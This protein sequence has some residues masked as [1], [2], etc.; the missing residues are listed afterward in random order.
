[1]LLFA[2]SMVHDAYEKASSFRE[3]VDIHKRKKLIPGHDYKHAVT[4]SVLTAVGVFNRPTF[5]VYAAVPLFY[6][7][8]RGIAQHSQFTPFQTFNFRMLALLPGS[9]AP[10]R[11]YEMPLEL[12]FFRFFGV[13]KILIFVS[14]SG[15]VFFQISEISLS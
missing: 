12:S 8:Q 7:F 11:L 13:L 3:R 6:W 14:F 2:Q 5:A 10:H 15:P 4:I 9:T 1:M